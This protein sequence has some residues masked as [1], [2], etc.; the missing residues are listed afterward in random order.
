M[1][2]LIDSKGGSVTQFA[3]PVHSQSGSA[4][5]FSESVFLMINT[6]ETG[7]TERQFVEMA[8]ALR[9]DHVP[10]HVGCVRKKGSPS[11][12]DWVVAEFRLGGSLYGLQSMRSRWRL[13]RHL[14]KIGVAVAHSFDFY[15][16]LTMI[17]A[18][19]LAGIPAVIGSHR[20]LGDLLTAGAVPR[21]TGDVPVVRS[22]GVQF[23]RGSGAVVAGWLAGAQGGGYWQCFAAG[24]VCRG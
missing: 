9:A 20:Q 4:P 15:T 3:P 13:Q 16:N 8:R 6:L 2:S 14:R 10:V 18:A 21:A 1:S 17:P 19:K 7:G 5:M 24:G 23:A 22:R 11:R 12:M